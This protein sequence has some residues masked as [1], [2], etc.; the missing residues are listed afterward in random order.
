MM[1]FA[2]RA[3]GNRQTER[4]AQRGHDSGQV[5]LTPSEVVQA[6]C[7]PA[8]AHSLVSELFTAPLPPAPGLEATTATR[9]QLLRKSS[10]RG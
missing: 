1:Y 6:D 4:P 9:K 3:K 10:L 5:R 7:S 2:R 8:A